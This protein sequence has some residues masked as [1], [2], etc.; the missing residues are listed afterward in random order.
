M[1]S[2][3]P[4]ERL[5]RELRLGARLIPQQALEEELK[6]FLGR[7]RHERLGEPIAGRESRAL[8]PAR[9]ARPPRDGSLAPVASCAE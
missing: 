6:E 1:A 5:R 7:E 4:S 9:A 2:M 3:V 8:R